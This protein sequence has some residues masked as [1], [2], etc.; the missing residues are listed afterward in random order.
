M[1]EMEEGGG[2]GRKREE[3]AYFQCVL[4]RIWVQKHGDEIQGQDQILYALFW[5]AARDL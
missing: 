1:E 5:V 3:R 4:V 2:T